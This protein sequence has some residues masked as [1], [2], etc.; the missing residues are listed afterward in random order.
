MRWNAIS[1]R[2]AINSRLRCHYLTSS[3]EISIHLSPHVWI[4]DPRPVFSFC[5]QTSHYWI[6]PD[7]V[8]LCRKLLAALII[9]KAM[10][11]ITFLPHDFAFLPLKTLPIANHIAHW[12]IPLKRNERVQMIRH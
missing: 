9:A 4:D 6:L 3:S 2:V 7:V 1:E 11:K 12:L 10:I 8:H 5:T